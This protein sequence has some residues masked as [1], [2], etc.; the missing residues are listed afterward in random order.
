MREILFRVKD[1]LS[2]QWLYGC[3]VIAEDKEAMYFFTDEKN[4]NF[5]Q[6]ICMRK[7]VGQYTGLIDKNGTKIF[8]G[9]IVQ[10]IFPVEN[11]DP[12]IGIIKFSECEKNL[13][14]YYGCGFHI[15]WKDSYLRTDIG[16]WTNYKGNKMEVIGNIH[17]NPELLHT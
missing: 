15:E 7:T 5:R 13:D 17:D 6:H 16:Y 14:N 11:A 4:G 2:G 12:D 3:P 9:D 8:E 1:D 10:Y